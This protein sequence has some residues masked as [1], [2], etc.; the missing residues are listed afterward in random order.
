MDSKDDNE[1]EIGHIIAEGSVLC[2]VDGVLQGVAVWFASYFVFNMAYSKNAKKTLTFIERVLI[3]M[4]GT[5]KMSIT[6]FKL[7]E[8]LNQMCS[9]QT[10]VVDWNLEWW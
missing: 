10:A 5:T 4:K 6:I 7:K 9:T 2:S 3:G 8:K 1:N